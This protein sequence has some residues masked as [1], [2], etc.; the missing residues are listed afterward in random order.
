MIERSLVILKPDVT[1]RGLV[2]EITS[3]FE[4]VGLKIVAM[5]MFN[6]PL[7]LAKMHYKK[8]DDWLLNVGKKL[9]KNQ[10]LDPKKEDPIHHG[11]KICESLA[12]D[13]TLYPVIA[14][15]LQGHNSIK[16]IRKLVGDQSPE[17]SLPG[18]IRGDYSQD[19]YVLANAYNRPVINL[20]H[21]S[22]S[23]EAAEK[24]IKLWF[25][26]REIIDWEKP[27]EILHFRRQDK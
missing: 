27:D 26:K 19:T 6:V 22:D 9:I 16:L 13:L 5:K 18:T 15:V 2:G 25:S 3:R 8:D 7:K 12:N 14:M 4:R 17:N 24:E 21:A 23:K 11:K 1:A 10:N 20:V